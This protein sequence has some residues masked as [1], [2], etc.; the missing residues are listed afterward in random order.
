MQQSVFHFRA[1]QPTD[2]DFLL[3]IENDARLWHLSN[4]QQP[5]SRATLSAY[6]DEAE[7]DIYVAKQQRFVLSDK[8][9]VPY[10]LIDLYDFDAQHQRAGVGIVIDEHHRGKGLGTLALQLLE[11]IAF[12]QLKLHQLYAGVGEDNPASIR[13]FLAAG[14]CETGRKKAWNYYH[15]DF[16]DEIQFQKFAHV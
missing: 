10:G 15:G 8:A 13:M 7:Q 11:S 14:Y 2:L 5:F 3:R 9:L 4:T 6:I 16:H 1:L 12:S